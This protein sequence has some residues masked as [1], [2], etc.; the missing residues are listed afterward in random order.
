MIRYLTIFMPADQ[1]VNLPSTEKDDSEYLLHNRLLIRCLHHNET[2]II[3]RTEA[4][5]AKADCCD[6]RK[7]DA[8]NQKHLPYGDRSLAVYLTGLAVYH[9]LVDFTVVLE[10]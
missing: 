4:T 5:A 2:G 7:Y 9:E 6:N 8:D 1:A 10:G 3:Q